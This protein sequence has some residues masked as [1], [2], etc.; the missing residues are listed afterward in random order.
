MP[1]L[2]TGFYFYYYSRQ[3]ILNTVRNTV[4]HSRQQIQLRLEHIL[5]MQ[6]RQLFNVLLEYE[7]AE[8]LQAPPPMSSHF[9][10]IDTVTNKI[11]RIMIYDMGMD[12][13]ILIGSLNNWILTTSGISD[14]SSMAGGHYIQYMLEDVN[15]NVTWYADFVH[16]D[17]ILLTA[18]NRWLMPDVIRLIRTYPIIG[19]EITG[20]ISVSIPCQWFSRI[21]A[22]DEY[23]K[24]ILIVDEAGRILANKG[25]DLHGVFLADS[26]YGINL[27]E[28]IEDNGFIQNPSLNLLYNF[29]VSTFNGWRYIYI[30]DLHVSSR[31]ILALR[32]ITLGMGLFILLAVVI[33]SFIRTRF[34]YKPVNQLYTRLA[35]ETDGVAVEAEN[36]FRVMYAHLEEI[37]N[38]R[39][40]LEHVVMR[41][42][43]LGREL[44]V[45]KILNGEISGQALDER[46]ES[47]NFV[48]CPP[49][50]RIALLRIESLEDSGYEKNDRDWLL[51]TLS[52]IGTE[53]LAQLL[54]LPIVVDGGSIVMVTGMSDD[55]IEFKNKLTLLLE[56]LLKRVQE[57]F[58]IDTAICVSGNVTSYDT[59]NEHR[60]QADEMFKY[61]IRYSNNGL[62][63]LEDMEEI[64]V[65]HP[66]FPQTLEDDIIQA[67]RQRDEKETDAALKSFIRYVMENENYRRSSYL[68]FSRLLSDILR[69]VQEYSVELSWSGKQEMAFEQLFT[70]KSWQQIYDWFKINFTDPLL[71]SMG[72][73]ISQKE[74]L[75]IKKMQNI[76]ETKYD[77][78]LSIEIIS[79]ELA[80]Y[81]SYLR[82][83]FKN[84]TGMSFNTYLTNCRMEA[85][86]EMLSKTDMRIS[87]IAEKLTYQHSQNFIRMFRSHSGMTPEE[88]RR[89]QFWSN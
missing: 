76:A 58:Q 68:I 73:R 74:T 2:V 67:L 29:S 40:E 59:L 20:Y 83:V 12:S 61:Q 8:L 47:Y 41:Q 36:E 63:F 52:D 9:Q 89:L 26:L 48:K 88:Y 14:I 10:L 77:N 81:P 30:S 64:P 21:L 55:E 49:Y 7:I 25:G 69:V 70:L 39:R 72:E 44:F 43:Q 32:T 11:S 15:D 23:A 27:P 37:L 4:T 18:Y 42:S 84:G 46:I 35:Y 16:K 75:L 66:Q 28:V 51:I 22:S 82:R 71:S 1:V 60:S 31:A 54:C 87:D 50:C 57:L 17:D 65:I 34:F 3:N 62:L 79:E 80:S 86:K 5:R 33:V 38:K 45:H 24:D 13:F 6:D 53:I 85:A 19:R 78:Y 56:N